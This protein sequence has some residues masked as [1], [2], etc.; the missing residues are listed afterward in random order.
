MFGVPAEDMIDGPTGEIR[1]MKRIVLFF[2]LF[3]TLS[4]T[5]WFRMNGIAE[6][7]WAK[8]FTKIGILCRWPENINHHRRVKGERKGSHIKGKTLKISVIKFPGQDTCSR[9]WV[10]QCQ[11]IWSKDE[12]ANSICQD[13]KPENSADGRKGKYLYRK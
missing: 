12:E 9:L 13:D 3:L 10:R 6:E 1:T 5:N 4:I 7:K 2:Q 8:N 11:S